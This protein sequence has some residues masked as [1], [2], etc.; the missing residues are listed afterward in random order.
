MIQV[1]LNGYN[2]RLKLSGD[3]SFVSKKSYMAT[4]QDCSRHV[5]Q[6]L[7]NDYNSRL[8]PSSDSSL[9]VRNHT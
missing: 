6:V 9:L 4:I 8:K 2:S 7:L 5:I 1:L 3:S